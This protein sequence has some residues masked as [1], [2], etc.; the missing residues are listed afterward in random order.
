MIFGEATYRAKMF[1]TLCAPGCGADS[2]S[3]RSGCLR[4]AAV[5][6]DPLVS[7]RLTNVS[8]GY[9]GSQT[10]ASRNCE[11]EILH[12]LSL[13]TFVA[14]DQLCRQVTAELLVGQLRVLPSFSWRKTGGGCLSN[15]MRVLDRQG[16]EIEHDRCTSTIF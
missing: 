9:C 14:I 15:M 5:V 4:F 6:A 7:R 2:T 12:C 13:V 10:F 11:S 8:Y 16:E 1:L 3:F